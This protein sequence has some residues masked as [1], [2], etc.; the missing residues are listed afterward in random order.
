MRMAIRK[1]PKRCHVLS[2]ART[3]RMESM[4]KP[5]ATAMI[6]MT[7]LAGSAL[8]DSGIEIGELTCKVVDVTNVV[9]YTE[10]TFDCEFKSVN[11]AIDSYK[12]IIQKIG[13]DLSIKD[14]FTL[15]WTVVAPTEVAGSEHALAGTYAGVGADVQLGVGVG[16]KVLVGGGDGSFSLQPVSV[17]GLSGGVGAALGIEEFRLR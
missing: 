5:V 2:N 16:A 7:L 11:G 13:V 3:K 10:Q 9:L 6:G 17:G 12:G 4:R 14:D 15:V 1:V 8:A